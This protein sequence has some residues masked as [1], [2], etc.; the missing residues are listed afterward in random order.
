[1]RINMKS[2]ALWGTALLSEWVNSI[3]MIMNGQIIMNEAGS[4][5]VQMTNIMVL[6]INMQTK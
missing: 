6:A 3:R 5:S 2:L 4:G 1:M